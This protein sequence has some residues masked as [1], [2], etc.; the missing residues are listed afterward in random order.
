MESKVRKENRI[1][2]FCGC[3]FIAII[4][5]GPMDF[6]PYSCGKKECEDARVQHIRRE[7]G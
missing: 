6:P 7:V 4:P 1:C 2:N 5:P 3:Q